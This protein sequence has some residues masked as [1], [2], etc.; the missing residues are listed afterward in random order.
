MKLIVDIGNTKVKAAIFCEKKI[1]DFIVFDVF[2]L[3]NLQNFIKNHKINYSIVSNVGNIDDAIINFLKSNFKNIELSFKVNLPFNIKYKTPETLGS[4]R[5]AL[6]VGANL[7]YPNNNILIIG[8]GT[9]ITYDFINSNNEYLGGAI[10]PGLEMR[11]KALNN[12]TQNLPLISNYSDN[13]FNF[14]GNTTINSIYSGVVNGI[15]FEIDGFIDIYKV[16]YDYLKIFLTGGNA[17]FF[18]NNLKN[19]IFANSNLILNGL[20]EII[21]LNT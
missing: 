17:N 3:E 4:D 12:Y 21:D 5:I 16:K 13:N 7:I 19:T 20:N 10:S 9:C 2:N 1:V 15:A 8:T 6:A 14:I 18:E 11:F